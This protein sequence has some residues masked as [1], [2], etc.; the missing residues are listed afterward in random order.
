LRKLDRAV[1]RRLLQHLE[2]RII[3]S[4][5]PRQF[6]KALRGDKGDL[7]SCRV[8]DYQIVCM[9]EDQRLVVAV[10]TVGN[11]REGYR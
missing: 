8:G 7:W 1:Q 5:D 3:A 11:R 10:V 9:I 6:G 2:Q 4:G